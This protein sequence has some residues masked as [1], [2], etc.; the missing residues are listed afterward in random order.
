MDDATTAPTQAARTGRQT[1][2]LAIGVVLVALNLRAALTVVGPL[3]GDLR[4]DEGLSGT[5]VGLLSTAPLL[6]FGLV[7]PLGPRV[8]ARFGVERALVGA[9]LVLTA[10]LAVRPLPPIALLFLGTLAAGCGIAIANVL[11]PAIVKRRFGDR[12]AF[13]TGIY[14][15]S[16]GVGAALAAGLAVPTAEWL[17]GWQGAFALWIV[18][19]A[20]AALVWLPQ[21]GRAPAPAALPQRVR[22]RLWRD[23]IA[24]QVTAFM[25]I[26]S[27]LFYAVVAWL[28]EIYRHEGFS[29]GSAGALL[30][31][32]LLVGIPMGFVVAVAASR[33]RDQRPIAVAA[34]GLTA[35]G[36]LGVLLAPT[37]AASLWAGLLGLGFGSGFTLVL[38]LMVLRAPDAHHAAELSGMAQ[39]V[40]Y[41]VA[42]IGPTVIGA[43][44]DLSGGWTLPLAVL[45]GL[46][47][48]MLLTALG[49]SRPGYVSGPAGGPADGA[50]EPGVVTAAG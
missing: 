23:R 4:D 40:G 41:T 12:A 28:P 50:A 39:S 10:G 32:S 17:D 44:H 49:G 29:K 27:I 14:S 15:V 1:L 22:V 13:M 3:I 43:L 30:S 20:L 11:L 48:P 5:A 7:A 21:A 25:A 37:A 16:L 42:A 18:P 9:M 36:L 31:L 33:I 2:L 45:C 46:C 24:R 47:A 8:A 6:A 26:Q 34:C 19:A 38:T 35:L